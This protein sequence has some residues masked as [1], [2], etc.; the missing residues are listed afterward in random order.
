MNV[1]SM[2][3]HTNHSPFLLST[4]GFMP[5]QLVQTNNLSHATTHQ[6][7]PT[8]VQHPTLVKWT[9]GAVSAHGFCFTVCNYFLGFTVSVFIYITRVI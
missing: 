1:Q 4:D 6:I 7:Q 9:S 5:V 3:V 2:Q 8:H